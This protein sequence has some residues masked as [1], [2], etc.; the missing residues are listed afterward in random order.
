MAI[1]HM[2][3]A[4]S[5]SLSHR[6]LLTVRDSNIYSYYDCSSGHGETQ[7]GW[8]LILDPQ[9]LTGEAQTT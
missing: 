4:L 1:W 9:S 7:M 3:C 6:K 5:R 8:S 2:I